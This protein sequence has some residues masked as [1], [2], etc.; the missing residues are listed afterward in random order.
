MSEWPEDVRTTMQSLPVYITP[1]DVG[2]AILA[3]RK[4]CAEVARSLNGW[5]PVGGSKVAEHIA[6]ILESGQ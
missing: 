4:Q 2:R 1:V 3:E 6:T 5:G